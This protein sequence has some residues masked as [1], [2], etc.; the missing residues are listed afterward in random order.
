MIFFQEKNFYNYNKYIKILLPIYITLDNV[1]YLANINSMCA[2][3]TLKL[4]RKPL[5]SATKGYT[6]L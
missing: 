2:R 4:H 3:I 6:T 1:L 5:K